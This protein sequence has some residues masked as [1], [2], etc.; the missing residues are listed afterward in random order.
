MPHVDAFSMPGGPLAVRESPFARPV[1][2]ITAFVT[3]TLRHAR[4]PAEVRDLE[5]DHGRAADHRDLE[6]MQREW[7]GRDG[8]GMRSWV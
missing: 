6:R 1:A 8:G 3:S 5:A 2:A 4:K 7:E